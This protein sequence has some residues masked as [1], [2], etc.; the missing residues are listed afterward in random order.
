MFTNLIK[1]VG[2]TCF[3]CCDQPKESAN[4]AATQHRKNSA[5]AQRVASTAGISVFVPQVN[6]TVFREI[7]R[8]RKII[9]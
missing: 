6:A 5:T 7:E 8:G 9:Y 4:I 3:L 1:G 2:V